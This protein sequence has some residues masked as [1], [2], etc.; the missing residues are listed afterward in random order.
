MTFL[1]HGAFGATPRRVLAAQDRIRLAVERQPLRFMM[2]DLPGA[3]RAAASDLAAF[4]GANGDDLAFV[5]NTTAGVN[6]ILRSFPLTPGDEVV[7]AD[8]V[9]PAVGKTLGFVCARAGASLRL[10][11]V[12]LPVLNPDQVV[13]A[14][15]AAITPATRLLVVDHVTSGSGLVFPVAAVVALG[16]RHGLPVLVDGAH[17]LG[18]LP[19]DLTVLGATWYVANCH[20]WLCAP[21][22]SA[23]L[24]ANPA[25]PRSRSGLHAPVISHGFDQPFP[26]EF[27][28]IGTRDVSAWLSVPEAVALRGALG[29]AAVRDH[30]DQLAA[31]G[32]AVVRAAIGGQLAGPTSMLG[33]MASVLVPGVTTATQALGDRLRGLLWQERIEVGVPA[34]LGRLLVRVSGQIY[35]TPDEYERL[36]AALPRALEA[37]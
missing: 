10:A 7:T 36:A 16:R 24:W 1:N 25:D 17:G 26:A 6:A 13:Q 27:D 11:R 20:K 2:E 15:A 8:H 35:N 34:L 5:E 12:G 9:Y 23:M 37:L 33:S 22:G 29:D 4:V 31:A 19:L 14:Y 18:M 30:N 28:W 3:L 32:A 21:K